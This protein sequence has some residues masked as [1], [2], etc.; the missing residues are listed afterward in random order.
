MIKELKEK[1]LNAK[2]MKEYH[3]NTIICI[4]IK[5]NPFNNFLMNV[6]RTLINICIILIQIL[7]SVDRKSVV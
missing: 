3:N 4:L 1:I 7:I 6:L 5:K 2:I